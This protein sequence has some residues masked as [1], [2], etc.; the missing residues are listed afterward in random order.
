MNL[1]SAAKIVR[2]WMREL[3]QEVGTHL[4]KVENRIGQRSSCRTCRVPACCDQKVEIHFFEAIAIAKRLR[5]ES[6]DTPELRDKLEEMGDLMT[7]TN[8]YDYRNL[9]KPCIF[10]ERYR[11]SIYKDRPSQCR[12]YHV[13]TPADLCAQPSGTEV[14]HLNTVRSLLASAEFSR[15]FQKRLGLPNTGERMAYGSLPRLTLYALRALDS[16]H[17][18]ELLRRCD[19]PTSA[20]VHRPD[21]ESPDPKTPGQAVTDPKS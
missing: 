18:I 20:E 7:S 16:M 1:T 4:Q 21:P 5:S 2:A 11:C 12:A 9:R 14:T 10:L 3:D 6:R 8:T 19:W 13:F 15:E 17:P